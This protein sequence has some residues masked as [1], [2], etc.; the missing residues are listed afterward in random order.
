MSGSSPIRLGE[1]GPSTIQEMSTYRQ[2]VRRAG[3]P[4]FGGAEPEFHGVLE[5]Q[6]RDPKVRAS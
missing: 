4:R 2:A 1:T 3:G 5:Q 6:H